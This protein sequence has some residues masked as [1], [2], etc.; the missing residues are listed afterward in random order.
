MD[1][2]LDHPYLREYIEV[3][4]QM[5][6]LKLECLQKRIT[7]MPEGKTDYERNE[8]ILE[9]IK[10]QGEIKA[11]ARAVA[12]RESYAIKFFHEVFLK[13][14]EDMEENY[15][16]V[17]NKAKNRTEPEIKDA[18]GRLTFNVVG[19]TNVEAK[20]LHFKLLKNLLK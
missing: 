8:V 15:S 12:E 18:L 9:K 16:V 17:V 2:K 7:L 19:N 14:I 3:P 1:T 5:H 20:I 10:T 4:L 13:D 11:L 6:K